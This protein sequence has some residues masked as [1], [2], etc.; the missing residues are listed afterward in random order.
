MSFVTQFAQGFKAILGIEQ[1]SE[2]D[3]RKVLTEAERQ[4]LAQNGFSG[5]F[6]DT[7]EQELNTPE[8]KEQAGTDKRMAIL[9]ATLGQV[10]ARLE[11]TA[12]ELKVLKEEKAGH[13]AE[14]K[15]KQAQIDDLAAKVKTLSDLAEPDNGT[16]VGTGVA[17]VAIND[18]AQLCGHQG[19]MF[20]LDRPYN[21]RA[22]AAIHASQGRTYAVS[23]ASE[24][25]YTTLKEDLGAFYRT[26]WK[27]KI[28]SM[29]TTLPTVESIWGLESGYQDLATL[30][31]L[32]VGEFS[33]AD[34]TIGSNFD[35]VTK[36][37]YEFGTE[38]LRMNSVMFAIK[39]QNLAQLERSW[40]GSMNKEGSDPIKMSFIEFLLAE[41]A[42]KLH[43]ERENRRVN[44]VRRNP[45]ANVPGRALEAADGFYEFIRKKVDGHIDYTPDG[46][47]TGR[48]VFQIKP[49][50]LG[51]ITPDNIGEV[52]YKGTAMIPAHIRDT[53]NV[54][55]YIPSPLVHLYHKYNEARYGVNQDYKPNLMVVKEFPGVKLVPVPNA[56][57]HFRLVWTLAG[58]VKCYEQN[59]GEMLKFKIEQQDWAIKVWSNWKEAVWAEV[60]GYKYTN[61]AEMDGSRQMIWCNEYDLADDYF[62][63]AKPDEDPSVLLHTS[64]VTGVNKSLLSITTIKDAKVG[65]AIAIKCGA[66][67]DA[68][69][70]IEKK[71]N[72]ALISAAWTPK[73]GD[74]IRLMKRADG[75]FVELGRET[76]AKRSFMFAANATAPSVTGAT[77][78]VVG[79]NT[80]ATE[81]TNLADAVVGEVYTIHGQGTTDATTIATG[82]NFS[83]TADI[84][85]KEGAMIKLVKADDGKFYEIERA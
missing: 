84:T 22:L 23:A 21:Q 55:C 78:F 49:F 64:V 48:T 7:F 46:G 44:G 59:A 9:S 12:A 71:D 52:I 6:L 18:P 38:T 73:V 31:N 8:V 39:F 17:A 35:S 20:A 83:L 74:V 4:T 85:L 41:T 30:V 72:F 79:V 1:F 63:A 82:G 65:Q 11:T 13:E 27:D 51:K 62:V 42:K 14:V 47:T 60:V 56:D 80:K 2:K 26:P 45:D 75:K 67:G 77:E 43:N 76:D 3:G 53:G 58:N 29:L 40:I 57:N 5:S 54:V 37:S 70:K 50:E 66:D 10:S 25:D 24:T 19:L 15:A 69:V 28:Q 34:N 16:H 32:W 61:K 33:Q 81:L 36:G 68:G